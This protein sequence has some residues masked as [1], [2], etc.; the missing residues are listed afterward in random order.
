MTSWTE[1]HPS[2]RLPAYAIQPL[3]ETGIELSRNPSQQLAQTLCCEIDPLQGL[4][5][6]TELGLSAPSDLVF[7]SPL[8]VEEYPLGEQLTHVLSLASSRGWPELP[9]PFALGVFISAARALAHLH[10]L[11]FTHG[12]IS[13]EMITLR[14]ALGDQDK[15]DP[16][17][18]TKRGAVLTG[19]IQGGLF[20]LSSDGQRYGR[21]PVADC[22]ALIW[23]FLEMLGG[24]RSVQSTPEGS[25]PTSCLDDNEL[26]EKT[27][28]AL[29]QLAPQFAEWIKGCLISPPAHMGVLI[30]QLQRVL[31]PSQPAFDGSGL[32]RWLTRL[33]PERAMQW[34]RVLSGSDPQTLK[35]LSPPQG[36]LTYHPTHFGS[37]IETE[38][39]HHSLPPHNVAS[40]TEIQ[41]PSLPPPTE[42]RFK[43]TEAV[44]QAQSLEREHR[45]TQSVATPEDGSRGFLAKLDHILDGLESTLRRPF[46]S[47]QATVIQLRIA[48]LWRDTITELHELPLKESITVST[49]GSATLKLPHP[50]LGEGVQSLI[51]PS[52]HGQIVVHGRRDL[53]GWVQSVNGGE[54]IAWSDLPDPTLTLV[55]I[56]GMGALI[57][58]EFGLFFHLQRVAPPA[59][60]WLPTLPIPTREAGFFWCFAIA[61]L[62]HLGVITASYSSK[63]YRFQERAIITESKFVEVISQKQERDKIEEEEEEEEEVDEVVE[64]VSEPDDS[65]V[66][67]EP[68]PEPSKIREAVKE[69]SRE[70]FGQG[71]KAVDA[72]TDFLS[73][74]SQQEGKLALGDVSAALGESSDSGLSLGSSFGEVGGTLQT[75]SGGTLDT[76]GGLT[77]SRSA[78]QLQAKRVRRTVKGRP[79]VKAI[80]SRSSITGG[81][82]S[83]AEISKVIQK[84]FTQITNCYE[85]AIQKSPDLSGKLTVKWVIGTDGRVSGVKQ[86]LS[87]VKDAPMAKCVFGVIQQMRFPKPKGGPVKIKYPFVFQQG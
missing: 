58:G 34:E 17:F 67:R 80:K 21:G 46:K 28:S 43:N 3:L 65:Y 70:R 2:R 49:D 83:Q 32:S 54:R 6:L 37:A 40:P 51:S 59:P 9:V 44:A 48:L 76:S 60:L 71:K 61:I 13:S 14:Y 85:R 8:I 62:A 64:E 25:I 35:L 11:G 74:A 7:A 72:L 63:I 30:S 5:Q 41:R 45:V 52:G 68:P 55:E 12:A 50:L 36:V 18:S 77:G 82:L 69:I 47:D 15:R 4:K 53:K 86:V 57:D 75:G 42:T 33:S 38:A 10:S 73:G 84:H 78:G 39:I 56:G 87:S 19:W 22:K 16:P 24:E 31:D 81:S 29:A 20:Q 66:P 27:E 23:V 26:T 79:K 1:L